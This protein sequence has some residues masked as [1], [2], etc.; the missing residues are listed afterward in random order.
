MTIKRTK[1]KES[2]S[3]G[4]IHPAIPP[5]LAR[6]EFLN[7]VGKSKDGANT[8]VEKFLSV[9]DAVTNIQARA[10]SQFISSAKL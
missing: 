6:T 7:R 10:S 1:T 5:A 4:N 2:V 9:M 8:Y 3:A